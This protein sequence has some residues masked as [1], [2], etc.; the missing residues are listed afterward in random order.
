MSNNNEYKETKR[1]E[2]L[3]DLEMKDMTRTALHDAIA[4]DSRIYCDVLAVHNHTVYAREHWEVL[5]PNF[6]GD[7][8]LRFEAIAANAQDFANCLKRIKQDVLK[9]RSLVPFE[10][11][12]IERRGFFGRRLS[13]KDDEAIVDFKGFPLRT[14]DGRCYVT[15]ARVIFDDIRPHYLDE[16]KLDLCAYVPVTWFCHRDIETGRSSQ[17]PRIVPGSFEKFDQKILDDFPEMLGQSPEP[18]HD[19]LYEVTDLPKDVFPLITGY[20]R[21]KF[22][23]YFCWDFPSKMLTTNK[24]EDLIL[25]K[26]LVG[27]ALIDG[28]GSFSEFLDRYH[29]HFLHPKTEAY[30]NEQVETKRAAAAIKRI[31]E[32]QDAKRL[33]LL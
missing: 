15:K 31:A 12:Q 24:D 3:N 2:D 30:Y 1:A 22:G 27:Q 26:S 4:K 5:T 9:F 14:A 21:L 6:L 33:R 13:R 19:I 28:V 20:L 17:S 8:A 10:N 32:S 29:I 7:Q 18:V 23:D 11:L 25:Q 16:G